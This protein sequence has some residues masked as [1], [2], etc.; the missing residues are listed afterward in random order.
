MADRSRVP[1]L[2]IA[3]VGFVVFMV[4]VLQVVGGFGVGT[5]ELLIW[6][7]LLVGGIVLIVGRY[8]AASRPTT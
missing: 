8:R 7:A 1:N 3:L 2:M 5:V 4:L 6:V